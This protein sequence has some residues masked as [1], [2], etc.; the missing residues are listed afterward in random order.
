[1]LT[2]WFYLSRQRKGEKLH[3]CSDF[4]ATR[5]WTLVKGESVQQCNVVFVVIMAGWWWGAAGVE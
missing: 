4:I 1:M 5:G 3:T 2:D